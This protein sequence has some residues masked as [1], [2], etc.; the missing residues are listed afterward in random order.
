MGNID[1]LDQVSWSRRL[2]TRQKGAQ[3]GIVEGMVE[4]K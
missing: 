4:T 2:T 3:I 1:R